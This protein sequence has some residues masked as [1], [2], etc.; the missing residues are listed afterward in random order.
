MRK[1]NTDSEP[2]TST[3]YHGDGRSL[4]H[5]I[6]VA[7]GA[8]HR[9]LEP[10]R[11]TRAAASW[12]GLLPWRQLR[13]GRAQPPCDVEA[14]VRRKQWV[15]EQV[16]GRGALAGLLP[17]AGADEAVEVARKTS[18]VAFIV[19]WLVRDKQTS[20]N[21]NQLSSFLSFY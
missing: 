14:A 10:A 7:D 2:T 1:P 9:L 19:V 12:L 5:A 8:T 4:L 20:T 15:R 18:Y 6:G 17:K 21:T 13:Q 3:R 16:G 11:A